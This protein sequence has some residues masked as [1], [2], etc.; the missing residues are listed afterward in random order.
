[1]GVLQS[2]N[3]DTVYNGAMVGPDDKTKV[4]FRWKLEDGNHRVIFGDLRAE[5]ITT[6]KLKTLEDH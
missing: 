3:K 4:L 1:M 2:R 6:E 5:T